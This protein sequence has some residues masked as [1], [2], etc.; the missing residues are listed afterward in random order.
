[1]R[2]TFVTPNADTNSLGRTQVLWQLAQ[3]LGWSSQTV[4]MTGE[5]IWAPV[6]ETEFGASVQVARLDRSQEELLR[7]AVADCDIVVSVKPVPE[8]MPAAL[9]VSKAFGKP[10]LQD[11]DDP[12]LEST[13]ALDSPIRRVSKWVLKR[14]TMRQARSLWLQTQTIPRM[15]SNPYLQRYTGGHLVPH[16]RP[17]SPVAANHTAPEIVVAFIGSVRAHKGIPLLREAVR[18]VHK[19]GFRLLITAPAPV[20]A[21]PWEDWVG[22]TTTAEGARLLAE[23]SIVATPSLNSPWARGQLPV[24]I[25]DAMASGVPVIASDVDPQPWAIGDAGLVVRPNDLDALVAA[26]RQLRDRD[27]RVQLGSAGRERVAN[28]FS[29]EAVAVSFRE[30]CARAVGRHST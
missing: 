11:I 26:L 10:I 15:V 4:A 22:V 12:D 25:I 5:T 28:T 16:A 19:E 24:K 9:A 27:L 18:Q 21:A 7:S 8:S 23:S 3:T 1:M 2:I 30:A 17:L 29:N 20:D 14:S 13:L 6:R